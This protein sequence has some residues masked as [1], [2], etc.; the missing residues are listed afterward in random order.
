MKYLSQLS[1]VPL[2]KNEYYDRL[3]EK[4]ILKVCTKN[5][6]CIDVGAHDGKILSLFI[7]HCP[8]ALHYAFEPLPNLYRLLVRKYTS[9]CVVHQ[10]ALSKQ[11]GEANYNYVVTRP[12]YSG[13]KIRPVT[14]AD[15]V[16][17]IQVQTNLLDNII[18]STVQVH[19]I[20]ID[21]EG[22]E[23][24]VLLGAQKIISEHKPC[25]LF[26]FGRG[27]SDAFEVT[28]QMMFDFFLSVGYDI[29]LLKTFLQNGPPLSLQQFMLHY[30]KGDEY[31][32]VAKFKNH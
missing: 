27:G 28:S 29:Y 26:E 19:L 32:F 14:P 9:A 11:Q 18:A 20:K 4:I 2:S 8:N 25:I 31:F 16:Q 10:L 15:Q 21:V 6:V 1:P 17:N 30:K 22:G 23:Y 3:T 12:A 7:K 13:L 5:S 24:D